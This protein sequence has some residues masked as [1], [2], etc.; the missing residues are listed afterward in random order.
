MSV[1]EQFLREFNEAWTRE[2]VDA[3]LAA[4]TEDIEF[5]MAGEK[6]VNGKPAFA[7]MLRKMVGGGG[8]MTLSIHNIIIDG[9]RAA[10]DGD[11]RMT[12]K[13]GQPK[14]YLFCDVYGLRDGKI[15][16]TTAYVVERK[17]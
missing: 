2:D 14:S 6:G 1:S 12:D 16:T 8:A 9:D 15:A 11:I 4:V 5:R 13:N 17:A 7:E 10:V 3:I